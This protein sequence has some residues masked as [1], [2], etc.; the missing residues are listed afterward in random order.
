MDLRS[1]SVFDNKLTTF[2][3]RAKYNDKHRWASAIERDGTL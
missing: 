1:N 3:H 2:V